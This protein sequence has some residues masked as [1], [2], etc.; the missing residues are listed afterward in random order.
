MAALGVLD[1]GGPRWLLSWRREGAWR[2]VLD[3]PESE[4]ELVRVLDE[5]RLAWAQATAL[6]LRY[7]NKRDL[8]PTPALFRKFLLDCMAEPR[9]RWPGGARMAA[10]F[11]SELCTDLSGS[12]VKPTALHFSAGQQQF[13]RELRQIREAASPECLRQ[14]LLGPWVPTTRIKSLGWESTGQR[15]YALRAQNPSGDPRPALPGLDWLA[16]RGLA[17]LPTAPV[18]KHL[19][20]ACC[21]GSWK[22]GWMRWPLWQPPASRDGVAALVVTRKLAALSEDERRARG[23]AAVFRA[24]ILRSASGGYGSFSPSAWASERDDP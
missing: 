11:G 1:A 19:R 3:G 23:V 14:A 17:L 16:F 7:G 22:H 15:S 24:R 5:D 9:E 6:Q 20:T 8:K 10:S 21:A 18:G 4:D 13:L 12:A 2:P